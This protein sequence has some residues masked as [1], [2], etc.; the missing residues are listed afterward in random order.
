MTDSSFQSVAAHWKFS[1]I[2]YLLITALSQIAFSLSIFTLFLSNASLLS[3][4]GFHPTSSLASKILSHKNA[5]VGPT[6]VSLFLAST[7]FS[8]LSAFLSFVTNS[9]TRKLEYEADAFAVSLGKE[10]A[11]NLKTA[12]VGIHEKNL[13]RLDLSICDSHFY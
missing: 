2:I 9:I 8:P 5:S 11:E 3:S 1:H 7:L 13:V 12:L 6:V 4:F 10:T